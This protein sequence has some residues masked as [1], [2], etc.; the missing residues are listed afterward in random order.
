MT[1]LFLIDGSP[2]RD[3]LGEIRVPTLVIHGADDPLFRS[4]TA[5]PSPA[6]S[7]AQS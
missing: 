5:A 4:S 3:R 7:R 1:N 2:Q 6:R